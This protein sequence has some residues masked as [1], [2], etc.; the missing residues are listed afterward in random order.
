MT[1]SCSSRPRSR[2]SGATSAPPSAGRTCS[3]R[4][5]DRPPAT[6]LAAT[7]RCAP[8]WQR[9]SAPGHAPSGSIS[10]SR[11][12]FPGGPVYTADELREDPHFRARDLLFAQD[13]PV[14][15]HVR[16]FGTPVKVDGERFAAT[17][18]PA[19]G[20]HT[21]EVLGGTLGLSAAEI[22]RLRAEGVV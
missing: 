12:T 1:G 11:T 15:G 21:A 14:A 3:R 9:S 17:P 20:E 19:P 7:R 8:S 22:E 6:T 10:S 16:L 5:P 2:S 18:A 4:S 13:H